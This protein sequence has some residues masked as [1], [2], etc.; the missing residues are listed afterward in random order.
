[1]DT[2]A[3]QSS[4]GT[5]SGRAVEC[6]VDSVARFSGETREDGQ[7]ALT[8]RDL[9]RPSD[10]EW[11]PLSSFSGV[12]ADILGIAGV[13]AARELGRQ[14]GTEA[15]ASVEAGPVPA[16]LAAV[17]DAY[18]RRHRGEAGGY[19]FR[20][21]GDHDGR[22]ECTTPYPCPFDQGFIGAV[23]AH[24]DGVVRLSEVGTCR[25]DGASRCTYQ[26]R[27]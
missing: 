17:D 23:A 11:Y 6:V 20:R 16:T 26:L 3:P 12:I 19:A 4:A 5:V 21:I 25:A 1:M 18:R 15:T 9:G 2:G 7:A 27:W 8:S 24:A 22:I 10:D 14:V 13:E